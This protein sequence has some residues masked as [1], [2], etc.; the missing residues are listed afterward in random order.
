M[1]FTRLLVP[2]DFSV[3]SRLVAA[4]AG[5]LAARLGADVILL[6]VARAPAGLPADAEVAPDGEGAS[7]QGYLSDEARAGLSPYV[8]AASEA[9]ASVSSTVVV[10]PVVPTIHKVVAES[11]ADLIVMGTHGRRGVARAL[12]GSVAEQT[13]RT[14]NVPVMMVRRQPRPE[15]EH[16]TCDWCQ[17]GTRTDGERAM[18]AVLEG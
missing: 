12:L 1:D 8:A 11:G 10:G 4:Q 15:C 3:C 17:L 6:H 5:A 16:A 2:V 13:L 7:V 9:G 14:A 18:A